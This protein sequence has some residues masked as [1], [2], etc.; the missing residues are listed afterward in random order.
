M[1][2]T[3]WDDEH[4]E[5]HAGE[6]SIYRVKRPTSFR[7][8]GRWELWREREG[9]RPVRIADRLQHG[10]AVAL[11][12]HL[13]GVPRGSVMRTESARQSAARGKAGQ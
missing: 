6:F 10:S 2:G 5:S 1:K 9:F 3:S 4:T 8:G 7:P 12:E 11:L 13:A